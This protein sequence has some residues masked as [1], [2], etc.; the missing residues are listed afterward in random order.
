MKTLEKIAKQKTI[1]PILNT[2]LVKS[3]VAMVTDLA[4]RPC[5]SF[6]ARKNLSC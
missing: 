2:V 4:N 3:G 6:S 1:Q 5:K